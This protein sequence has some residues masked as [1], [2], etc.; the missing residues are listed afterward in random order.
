M[1]TR[2][3]G[4]PNIPSEIIIDIFLLCLPDEPFHRPHPQTAPILLTHVCSSWREFAS[5]LPELWTSISL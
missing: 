1:L 5:R 2:I 3:D 4:F